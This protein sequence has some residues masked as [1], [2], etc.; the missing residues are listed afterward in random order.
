MTRQE[1]NLLFKDYVCETTCNRVISMM[2]ERELKRLLAVHLF[3]YH[4]VQLRV[5]RKLMV[6]NICIVLDLSKTT[7]YRWFPAKEFD[8][9]FLEENQSE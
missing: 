5:D 4:V 9:E 3:D 6:K 7:I 1:M 2:E 8:S